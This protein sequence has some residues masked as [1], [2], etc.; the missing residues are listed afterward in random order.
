MFVSIEVEISEMEEN[1]TTTKKEN[2]NT[3]EAAWEKRKE[4]SQP[5]Y[6]GDRH[7]TT[8]VN[9]DLQKRNGRK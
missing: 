8:D 3:K 4:G 9:T 7:V 1:E 5:R 2:T 6:R